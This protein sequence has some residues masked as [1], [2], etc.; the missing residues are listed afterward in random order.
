MP[1]AALLVDLQSM[2]YTQFLTFLLP[3]WLLIL[4]GV[5]PAAVYEVGPGKQFATIGAAP[6]TTLQPGDTVRI[7]YRSTPYKEKWVIC[8]QGTASAPI[9]VQGVPG[10]AG[11]LPVIEG[12]DAVTSSQFSFWNEDRGIIK[13]GGASRP[14]DT[15]PQYIVIEGLEIR[16]S[17]TSHRFRSAGG[18]WGN[19]DV[20]A[21]TVYIEKC[22]QCTI[23]NNVLHDSGNVI[24][25]GNSSSNIVISG[26]SIFGGGNVGSQKEHN[27]YTEALGILFEGNYMGPT[28]AGSS[29][30]N[31]K[32]RSAGTV[33]RYNWIEGGNRQLDLV[34]SGTARINSDATYRTTHVYGNVLIENRNDGNRQVVMYGGDNGNQAIYRKGV[35]HFY[36]NTVFSRRTDITVVFR[37]STLDETVEAR[38]NIFWTEG[39]GSSLYIAEISG[40]IRLSRNWIKSGF[41]RSA[42]TYLGQIV[43]DGTMIAGSSPG[44]VDPVGMGLNLSAASQCVNAGGNPDPS[45]LPQNAVL[46]QYLKV[47]N[48]EPRPND[49]VFDIGAFERAGGGP[50]SGNQAPVASI[51]ALP[52]SGIAPLTVS[53]SGTS[54]YDPD[55]AIATWSWDYGDGTAS[56]GVTGS[57]VYNSVGAFT[58]QLR[59]TDS[60]GLASSVTQAITVNPLPNPTLGGRVVAPNIA[61]LG[62]TDTSGGKATGHRIERKVEPS[63]AWTFV[64]N[65]TNAKEFEEPLP[66]GVYSYRVQLFNSVT[67]SAYSNT[68]TLTIP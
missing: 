59:V 44:F 41:R 45:V 12:I 43:D 51:L 18:S 64:V 13:I 29:G 2:R 63:G 11:E 68:K 26:N 46:R 19:Y 9:T 54:S 27:T 37:P 4:A 3:S 32:D 10:P 21:A 7:Y 50:S 35:L 8:R 30:N 31:L 49:G 28:L 5:A 57:H 48:T 15:M 42:G 33:V 66:P 53:F 38:N 55:G 23:R 17:R 25:V 34:D 60:A 1:G 67:T 6:W 47:R 14:A 52:A 36:N 24:F 62:W 58:V 20:R 16:S 65:Q 22:Q 40:I 56:S 39:G 61:R